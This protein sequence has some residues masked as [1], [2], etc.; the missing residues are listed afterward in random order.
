V[1]AT[2]K[3]IALLLT[4]LTACTDSRPRADLVFIQ[5]AEPETIDPAL[6]TDQVSMRISEAVFEGLCRGDEHGVSQPAVAERWE[7][8]A[9]KKHYTFHLRANATWSNGEAVTAQDFVY[10]WQRAL[11]PVLG[12][13][14]A[15]QLYV[16]KNARALNEGKLADPS[17]LGVHATDARTLTVELNDPTPYFI[18]LCAFSTFHPVHRATLEKHGTAWI[19]P[20]NLVGNGAFTIDEWLLD[21]SI[22]LQKRPDYWDAAHVSLNSVEV[23]PITD[24]NTALNYFLSGQADLMMDKG[25]VPP[26][27]APK[28]KAL[29]WFHTGPFLGTWFIRLNVTKP[30]FDK[31]LVR[32]AFALAIDKHRIV[33]KITQLGEPIAESLTPPGAGANYQPPPGLG[34][35][36]KRARELLAQAGYPGG[37][38]LPRVEYLHLPLP[39]ERNIAVELQA[40]WKDVLGVEVGLVKQEQKAW[41][42]SMRKL[43]YAMCRSSWVG[44]YND[45]NTFLEMFTTGNGNNRTGFT[46][47]TYDAAIKVAASEPDIA[48]RH[49]IFQ[50]AE[51]ELISDSA[52]IVPIYFYVGVQFYRPNEV[53]GAVPNLID[54]HPFRCMSVTRGAP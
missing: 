17:L 21:D 15:S 38:G 50:G 14:Y 27:L 42:D 45:A 24:A 32:Q 34:F 1:R 20:A 51:R 49:A 16:I 41:L 28:L 48:R 12:A 46:S 4:L 47:S 53:H 9:D 37:K 13:D 52:A 18:D 29:P 40:M 5:S 22:R 10:A 43:D 8:S 36:P 54:T 11:D 19:K 7:I 33:E 6:V 3:F 31:P 35:D 39:I 30:P 23:R 2:A 25:M 44:D 26:S